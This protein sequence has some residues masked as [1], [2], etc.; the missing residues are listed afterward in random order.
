[1]DVCP[2]S[3]SN[4]HE[5]HTFQFAYRLTILEYIIALRRLL[6]AR[7]HVTTLS[8]FA[9]NGGRPPLSAASD[10]VCEWGAYIVAAGAPKFAHPPLLL[11]P[12]LPPLR[13]AVGKLAK[14]GI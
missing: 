11:P 6:H 3:T 12:H 8:V 13:P 9:A 10:N 14:L 4:P 7:G 5:K 2:S 1:M